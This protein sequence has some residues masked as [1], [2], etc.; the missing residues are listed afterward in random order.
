M[1]AGLEGWKGERWNGG[2]VEWCT[3]TEAEGKSDTVAVQ[4]T[5]MKPRRF[6]QELL[7][8]VPC[9]KCI[10]HTYRLPV[11]GVEGRVKRQA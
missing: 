6:M 10:A 9:S 4:S 2:K 5:R 7:P 3:E 8:T 11:R 1:L